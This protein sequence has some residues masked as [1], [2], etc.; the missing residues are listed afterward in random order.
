M[1]KNELGR[2]FEKV[3][4][5]VC[6]R[7]Q[8]NGGIEVDRIPGLPNVVRRE[9]LLE[10][11]QPF[12]VRGLESLLEPSHTQGLGHFLNQDLQEDAAGRRCFVFVQM[13]D[14][15]D[16]PWNRVRVEQVSK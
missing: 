9:Q 6:E 8:P 5:A 12:R 1:L 11:F 7:T 15:Q 13:N 14:G 4:K 10:P 16:T 3:P 2:V